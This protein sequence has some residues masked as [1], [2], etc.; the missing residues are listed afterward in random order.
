MTCRRRP[1][2]NVS[3]GE[4]TRNL[5]GPE[6]FSVQRR[7]GELFTCDGRRPTT[8]DVRPT[9]H[10]GV[11]IAR[12]DQ[13]RDATR[14]A[15]RREITF[16]RRWRRRWLR[17]QN[18]VGGKTGTG[19]SGPDRTGPDRARPGGPSIGRTNERTKEGKRDCVAGRATDGRRNEMCGRARRRA[20]DAAK[21]LKSTSATAGSG[22]QL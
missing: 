8:Y 3:Y 1:R 14:R 19:R 20:A 7:V 13:R 18:V 5:L 12:R 6:E 9:N 15:V 11:Q 21:R 22:H 17:K 4:V 2:R 16:S 10:D